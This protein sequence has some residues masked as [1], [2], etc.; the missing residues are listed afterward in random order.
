[1]N[2]LL[3]KIDELRDFTNYVRPAVLGITESKLDSSFMNTSTNE[4]DM[5]TV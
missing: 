1:M 3:S 4:V 5:V 2:S